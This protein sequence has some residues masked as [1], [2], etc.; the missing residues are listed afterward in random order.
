EE[1]KRAVLRALK[2]LE[3]E[4]SVGKISEEDYRVLVGQYRAEA[5]RLLRMLEEDVQPAREAVEAL[6]AKRLRRAGL[7]DEEASAPAPD[8]KPPKSEGGV[9]AAS[10]PTAKRKRKPKDGSPT[11]AKK[12]Q[13]P[14]DA[15]STVVCAACG[16]ANDSDAVFCKKC[17]KR[18]VAEEETN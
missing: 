15:A 2:D 9:T 14:A 13:A 10:S 7:L 5:K 11:A 12:S 17:G 3:F 1:Q 18:C 16:A 8:S 4:R 6:V